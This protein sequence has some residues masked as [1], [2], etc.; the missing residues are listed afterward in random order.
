VFP[1]LLKAS[2]VLTVIVIVAV[3]SYGLYASVSRGER[4]L[5]YFWV[6]TRS[7][8]AGGLWLAHEANDQTVAGDVK[9]VS[10]LSGYFNVRVDPYQ[11]FRYLAGEGSERPPYIYTYGQMFR[12]GYVVGGGYS[13]DLPS[14][15][16]ERLYGLNLLYSNSVVNIY[17]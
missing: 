8:Y 10:L 5:G 15:W 16:P 4:Y 14:D 6:Y 2:V 7:E 3:N 12:N 11:G 17:G 9:V 13:I 1:I